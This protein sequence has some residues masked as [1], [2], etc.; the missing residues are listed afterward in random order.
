MCWCR[1]DPNGRF[2]VN[3]WATLNDPVG[4]NGD[5]RPICNSAA[6]VDNP[7]SNFFPP[8]PLNSVTTEN[9]P[10]LHEAVNANRFSDRTGCPYLFGVRAD[11]IPLQR[12]ALSLNYS[13]FVWQPPGIGDKSDFDDLLVWKTREELTAVVRGPIPRL[14]H[15]AIPYFPE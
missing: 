9:I 11:A 5:M 7:E 15:M 4:D 10:L 1:T 2:A 3:H 8:D 14:P 13:F 6:W 12:R